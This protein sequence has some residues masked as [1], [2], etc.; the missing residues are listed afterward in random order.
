M[1]V[2]L[3]DRVDNF[4][5]ARIGVDLAYRPAAA[6]AVRPLDGCKANV[7]RVGSLREV[8]DA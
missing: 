5:G 4:T 7:K 2:K 3:H 6:G 8:L 1:R